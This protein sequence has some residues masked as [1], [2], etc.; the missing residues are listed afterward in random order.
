MFYSFLASLLHDSFTSRIKQKDVKL[1]S[2]DVYTIKIIK[3]KWQR[4]FYN[5]VLL[6]ELCKVWSWHP[7]INKHSLIFIFDIF[8]AA[9]YIFSNK[10][11][12]KSKLALIQNFCKVHPAEPNT[13]WY[14][15]KMF[16]PDFTL[17]SSSG[18]G[19]IVSAF[20]KFDEVWITYSKSFKNQSRDKINPP[21]S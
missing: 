21:N 11:G 15:E 8:L 17:F 7:L 18:T 4:H 19:I 9:V 2:I 6:V 14:F 5:A 10:Y 12:F 16:E 1:N 20:L 13:V 3:F